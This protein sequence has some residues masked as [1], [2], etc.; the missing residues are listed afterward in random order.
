MVNLFKEASIEL[1]ID[2]RLEE[3]TSPMQLFSFYVQEIDGFRYIHFLDNWDD[4]VIGYEQRLD[5]ANRELEI[6]LV[7][8]D[9]SDPNRPKIE[10]AEPMIADFDHD[11]RLVHCP[12]T[13]NLS[14]LF[15]TIFAELFPEQS[16]TGTYKLMTEY[17]DIQNKKQD[18]D[19]LEGELTQII[20]AIETVFINK[21]I[22]IEKVELNQFLP[23]LI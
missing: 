5:F 17:T 7:H 4:L 22:S 13:D 19:L 15:S 9:T 1:A 10:S 3:K 6:I 21:G 8:V 2:Q 18:W 23:Y 12:L 20:L 14:S 11:G 16:N